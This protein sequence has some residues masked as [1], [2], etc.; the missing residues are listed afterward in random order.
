MPPIVNIISPTGGTVS[1][2]VIIS[3]TASDL[4]G[5]ST[6]ESV[7]VKIADDWEYTDGITDWSYNWDTTNLDDGNYTI[8][9]RA[10]DGI[11]HSMIKSVSLYVDNP[12][13]PI[14]TITS[15]IPKTMSG[16]ITIKG[17]AFDSD[18]EVTKIEIQIDDGEWKEVEGTT[19]WSYKLDTT[20][21]SDGEHTLRIRVYDDEGEYHIETFSII[22]N[23]SEWILWLLLVIAIVL[24]VIFLIVGITIKKRK[25]K[26]GGDSVQALQPAQTELQTLRCPRCNNVFKTLQSSA[27]IQCPYCGLSGT[28]A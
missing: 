22:V 15:E 2:T 6:I 8:Y 13:K 12:H 14:L 19:D 5:D 27:T 1:D 23:N 17:T 18:G 26:S 16:T 28:A 21:I 20:E 7:Q 3:G 25:A 4:D 10:F 9:V 11:D 24:F